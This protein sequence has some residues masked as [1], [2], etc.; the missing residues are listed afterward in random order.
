MAPS[1]AINTLTL[2]AL[3]TLATLGVTVMDQT[4]FQIAKIAAPGITLVP[5]LSHAQLAPEGRSSLT[6]SPVTSL[7]H[8]RPVKLVNSLLRELSHPPARPVRRGSI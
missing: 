6:L 3:P 2:A 1:T 4:F 8:V 7:W 5:P